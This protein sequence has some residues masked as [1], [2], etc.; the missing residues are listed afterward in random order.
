MTIKKNQN[1]Q[2]SK[3]SGLIKEISKLNINTS[4][5]NE[6]LIFE[7]NNSLSI[8]DTLFNINNRFPINIT[9]YKNVITKI[10]TK[11]NCDHCERSSEYKFQN[12]HLCWFHAH[13]LKFNL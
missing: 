10:S 5:V 4:I 11:I 2:I 12:I 6:K 3:I 9:N 1:Q 13:H 7:L 8:L